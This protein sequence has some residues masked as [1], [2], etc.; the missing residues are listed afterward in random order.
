MP[1]NNTKVDEYDSQHGTYK[2]EIHNLPDDVKLP[3]GQMP[4]APDPK[5]F[6]VGSQAP[7][8]R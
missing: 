3:T 5:P 6:S 7:G 4:Q 8:G 1:E 2:D